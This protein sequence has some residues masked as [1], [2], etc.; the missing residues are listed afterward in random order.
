MSKTKIFYVKRTQY[1]CDVQIVNGETGGGYYTFPAEGGGYNIGGKHNYK[2]IG[3]WEYLKLF[4][5][6]A[7]LKKFNPLKYKYLNRINQ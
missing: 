3:Y 7:F 2:R 4:I 5:Y 6:H 1:G